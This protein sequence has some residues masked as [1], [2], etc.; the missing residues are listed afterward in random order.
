MKAISSNMAKGLGTKSKVTCIDNSGAKKLEII[1][2]RGFKGKRRTKPHAGVA[3]MV[4]CKVIMGVEKVRYKVHKAVI[5]RQRREYRRP[6]GTRISF[7]DNAAVIVNDKGEI[8]GNR[9][10]GPVAKEAVER[11]PSIGKIAKIIV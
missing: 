11:F 6:D 2:V 10:K 9:I 8:I 1:S 3:D 4:N 5:V 7:E